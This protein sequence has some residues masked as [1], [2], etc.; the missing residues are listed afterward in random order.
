MTITSPSSFLDYVAIVNAAWATHMK[1]GIF[2][3]DE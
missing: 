3:I 2:K 1:K